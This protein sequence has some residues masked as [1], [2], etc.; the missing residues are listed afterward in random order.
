MQNFKMQEYGVAPL[1]EAEKTNTDGGIV[2]PLAV[3]VA[4]IISA[5]NN[6]GDIRDGLS[7]GFNG[8]TRH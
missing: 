1:T 4:I 6:F 8:T 5:A 3:I 7:D 2:W